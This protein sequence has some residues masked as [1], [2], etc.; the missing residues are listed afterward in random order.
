MLT[1]QRLKR[2]VFRS[3]DDL[4]Q[5]IARYIREHHGNAKPFAWTKPAKAPKPF[6]TNSADCLNLPSESVH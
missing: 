6:S 3:V 1:R 4:E 2:G 5:A